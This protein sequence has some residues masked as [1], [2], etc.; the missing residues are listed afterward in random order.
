M[1]PMLLVV[2]EG[3]NASD[4]QDLFARRGFVVAVA[5]SVTA[6]ERYL[7]QGGFIPEAAVLDFTHADAL[8]ALRM[9][10]VA[11]ARPILVGIAAQD[12][13]LRSQ[14]SLDAVFVPPVDR[15]RLFVRVLELV[16]RKNGWRKK[17]ANLR[18]EAA[19]AAV[20]VG[21]FVARA[22]VANARH[23]GQGQGLSVAQP[24]L[25]QPVERG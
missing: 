3:S 5:P 17:E 23:R 18:M 15:A 12:E 10:E 8:P 4:V 21:D 13:V 25:D 6:L 22:L 20:P 9:L 1:R 14:G 2:A 16:I 19:G 7:S 24:P 11:D